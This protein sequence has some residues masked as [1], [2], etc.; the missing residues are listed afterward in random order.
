MPRDPNWITVKDVAAILQLDTVT[1][2][3]MQRAGKLSSVKTFK[4]SATLYYWRPD[5]LAYAERATRPAA[6][7]GESEG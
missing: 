7:T 6:E 4:P 3:R 2:W 5:V 1:V